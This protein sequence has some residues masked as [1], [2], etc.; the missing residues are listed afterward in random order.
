MSERDYY[1]VLGISRD[2]SPDDI[3]KAYRKLARKYHPDVNPDDPTAEDKFKEVKQAYDVLSDPQKRAGYDQFGSSAFG[4]GGYQSGPRGFGDF[5]GFGDI[6]DM[7]FGGGFGSTSAG[8]ARNQPRQGSDLRYD[9]RITLEEAVS[10]AGRDIELLRT[11]TCPRCKGTGAEPGT[12]PTTCNVCGGTGQI[13]Q[14][15]QTALGQ[16]VNVA[17]CNACGGTGQII[18]SPCSTCKGR[19]K[20][21]RKRRIQVSVPPGVDTGSQIRIS[22]EGEAGD[23]GGPPGDLYV[24]ITVKPHRYFTRQGANILYEAPL[25]FTQA[26]LGAE[27][28]VPTL[29]GKAKLTI[30][31]GTQPGARFR[32]RGKG[33]P[34]LRRGGRGDQHV[35][36][37]VQVPTRLTA[38][39]RELLQELD[40]TLQKEKTEERSFFEK[41]RD[42]FGAN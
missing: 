23:R 8:R 3:K 5:A 34:H 42:A 24:Y 10:G 7:F 35:R 25:T 18:T 26:A 12:H 39:Q 38:K 37:T 15:R 22:N 40:E 32:L 13:K 17:P 21:R 41:M 27:I 4:E 14:V 19:G 30:P 31:Q 2:A 20:V 28:E 29:H 16:M 33:V 9:L 36:V 11:E 6:F 1:E